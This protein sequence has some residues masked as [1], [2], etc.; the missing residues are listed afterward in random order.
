MLGQHE[1]IIIVL[2]YIMRVVANA[3]RALANAI[4]TGNMAEVIRVR[5]ELQALHERLSREIGE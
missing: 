2:T 3:I 1:P 4:N 5:G